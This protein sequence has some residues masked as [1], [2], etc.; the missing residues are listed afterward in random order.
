MKKENTISIS[1][2]KIASN[3]HL[4]QIARESK[5]ERFTRLIGNME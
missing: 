2:K 1:N 5:K 4:K 3:S